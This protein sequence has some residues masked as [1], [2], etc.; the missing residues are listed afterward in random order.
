MV[1][2]PSPAAN[3]PIPK[4]LRALRGAEGIATAKEFAEKLGVSP[5]RYGNIEAGSSLSIEIALLI[6]EAVPGVTLDWLYNGKEDGLTLSLR[7]RL[8]GVIGGATNA[9]TTPSSSP[10]R[11]TKGKSRSST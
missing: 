1:N 2:K 3:Q 8:A 10:S 5:N 11:Q 6:V 9:R 4:R 7:Q